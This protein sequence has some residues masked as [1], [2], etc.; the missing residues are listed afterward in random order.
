MFS[1]CT[2]IMLTFKT[3]KVKVQGQNRHAE[4]LPLAMPRPCF[5]I[6][7]LNFAIRQKCLAINI[8]CNRIQDNGLQEVYTVSVFLVRPICC[9]GLEG[10]YSYELSL[11]LSLLLFLRPSVAYSILLLLFFD[12][13]YSIPEG[14]KY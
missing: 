12:P 9:F 11:S 5:K 8:D 6:F 10:V 7:S 1:I 14:I 3:V 2:K 13:Q 4:N